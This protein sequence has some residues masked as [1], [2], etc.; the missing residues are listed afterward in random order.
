[1]YKQTAFPKYKGFN[2]GYLLWSDYTKGKNDTCSSIDRQFFWNEECISALKE[3]I[4]TDL[5][6][7]ADL[8]FNFVRLPLNYRNFIANYNEF[9]D[10]EVFQFDELKIAP[11][12]FAV[13][14]AK[15]LG[16]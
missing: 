14:R 16:I 6:M 15:E 5:E 7:I 10:G 2:L 8:G 13:E 12:D 11:I 1:M 9:W 3:R 4:N